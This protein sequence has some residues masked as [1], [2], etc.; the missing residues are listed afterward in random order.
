MY[1]IR[2]GMGL[3]DVQDGIMECA[4]RLGDMGCEIMGCVGLGVAR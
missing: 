2:G 3:G 4:V 1:G